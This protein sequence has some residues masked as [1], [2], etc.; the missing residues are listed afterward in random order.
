[1]LGLLKEA[2]LG[3]INDNASRLSAALAYY[4]VFSLAPLLVIVVFI[5]GL[6]YGDQA[7]RGQVSDQLASLMGPSAAGTVE[8]AIEATGRAERSGWIATSIGF[9]ALLFGATSVLGELKNSLN[10]IWGVESRPGR[11]IRSLVRDRL[12]GFSLVLCAGFL[13]VVSLVVSSAITAVNTVLSASLSLPTGFWKVT[14]FFISLGVTTALFAL[15]FK[16]LPDVRLK[17]RHVAAGGLVT[18]L[19]FT[20][21]KSAIAWYLGTSSVASSF[22]AA[23]SLVAILLWVY[24][25]TAILFFGAEFTKAWVRHTTGRVTPAAHARLV[26]AAGGSG[27]EVPS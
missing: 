5:I 27:G 18:G 19:L 1:M 3:W 25:A 4:T 6:A 26:A 15:I 23:G 17:W 22:G 21:G 24:Y 9:G 2:G 14:D 13:L 7:A 20:A 12:L 11:A 16:V 8:A 10:I